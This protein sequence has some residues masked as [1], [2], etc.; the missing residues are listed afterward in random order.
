MSNTPAGWYPDPRSTRPGAERWW[1]GAAWTT[2]LRVPAAAAPPAPTP[3]PPPTSPPPPATPPPPR[4][5]L[6]AGPVPSSYQEY[7]P[8]SSTAVQTRAALGRSRPWWKRKRVLIP[9]G[10]VGLITAASIATNDEKSDKPS[11]EL[12]AGSQETTSSSAVNDSQFFQPVKE[13]EGDSGPFW[14]TTFAVV[15]PADHWENVEGA[16][17]GETLCKPVGEENYSLVNDRGVVVTPYDQP[18]Q[19]VFG[20]VNSQVLDGGC[21]VEVVAMGDYDDDLGNSYLLTNG[22]LQAAFTPEQL[23][24]GQD[25]GPN[26]TVP[27]VPVEVAPSPADQSSTTGTATPPPTPATNAPTTAAPTTSPSTTAEPTTTRAPTTQAVYYA[28]CDAVRAA[29][30]APLHQGEP[31]YRKALDRDGDGTACDT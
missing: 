1:D 22:T 14:M 29:G 15:V 17:P 21:R 6:R 2:H 12:A 31:G 4:R 10:F 25:A 8:Y 19:L 20:R 3:P 7:G 23:F 5:S 26:S 30:A 9:A 11:T 18:Q 13:D 27:L 28:N 16:P 24:S